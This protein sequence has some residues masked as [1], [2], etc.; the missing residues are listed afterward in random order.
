VAVQ[1]VTLSGTITATYDGDR[2]PR[3][4]IS[5]YGY[6]EQQDEYINEYIRLNSP[7]ANAPWTIMIP[8]LSSPTVL[9]FTV[10]GN[11]NDGEEIFYRED[12]ATRTVSNQNVSGISLSVE[13]QAVTLSGTLNVTYGG[14]RVPHVQ[15]SVWGYNDGSYISSYTSLSSPGANAPW[16]IKVP[17][18]ASPVEV[19]YFAI[20][21]Y[22]NSGFCLFDESYYLES[23]I[24]VSNTSIPGIVIDLEDYPNY[25]EQPSNATPLTNGVWAN[26]NIN[27]DGRP[28]SY[29]FTATAG[30]TYYVWWN[31]YDGDGT[32]T[33]N[34]K[35]RAYDSD[36]FI[37]FDGDNGWDYSQEVSGVSGTVYL[38]VYPYS[39]DSTGNFAIA[40]RNTDSRP[41]P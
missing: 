13:V 17:V 1:T 29:S 18:P 37:I 35:V 40:Y 25:F 38:V 36:G 39:S 5:V 3:V 15:I 10:V 34:V 16:S 2:V 23:P 30:Q 7:N 20:S 4:E 9:T 12:I 21:G 22:S 27:D 11:T 31:D 28:V 24:T 6:N 32:Y 33:M 14:K 41:T 19:E 26:G 8:A